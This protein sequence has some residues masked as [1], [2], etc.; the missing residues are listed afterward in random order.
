MI[1]NSIKLPLAQ[2]GADDC[3]GCIGQGSEPNPILIHAREASIFSALSWLDAFDAFGG[4]VSWPDDH[5]VLMA[6]PGQ[7]DHA[8]RVLA[9]LEDMAVA[10]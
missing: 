9:R 5:P 10:A 3:T 1:F 2:C 7:R 6:T 8:R 4:Y